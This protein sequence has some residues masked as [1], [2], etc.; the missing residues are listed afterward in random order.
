[1]T[2]TAF[3]FYQALYVLFPLPNHFSSCQRENK[4]KWE[5]KEHT[6]IHLAIT[7]H[8]YTHLKTPFNTAIPP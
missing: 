7:S 1:M 5:E 3:Y 6:Q 8:G 4:N 2:L